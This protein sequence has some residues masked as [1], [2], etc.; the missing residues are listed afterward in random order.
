MDVWQWIC[1]VLASWQIVETLRHG[2]L[3]RPLRQ[4]A[5]VRRGHPFAPVAWLAQLLGCPFCLS[6][7]A[8]WLPLLACLYGPEWC[9]LPVYV[10]GITRLTQLGNDL[11]HSFSR[12]PPPDDEIVIDERTE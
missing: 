10:L 7:W 6:H 12:S 5:N 8:P 2:S 1:C 9:L 4:W 11:F 3:F